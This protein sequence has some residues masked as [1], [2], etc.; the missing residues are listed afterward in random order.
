MK[1]RSLVQKALFTQIVSLQNPGDHSNGLSGLAS[2]I[3]QSQRPKCAQVT[4][5]ISLSAAVRSGSQ[6]NFETSSPIIFTKLQEVCQMT[7][8]IF[9]A[10][11]HKNDNY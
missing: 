7:P 9:K 10:F 2:Q 3:D 6:E 8:S 1:H 4:Q 5:R 11:R